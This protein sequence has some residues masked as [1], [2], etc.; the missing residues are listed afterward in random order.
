[1]PVVPSRFLVRVCVA[2]L[3]ASALAGVGRAQPGPGIRFAVP[4]PGTLSSA[5]NVVYGI[6]Q[7]PD[8]AIWVA[9][10][11]GLHRYDGVAFEAFRADPERPDAMPGNRVTGVSVAPDGDVWAAVDRFGLVR[12][13]AAGR[14]FERFRLPDPLAVDPTVVVDGDGAVWVGS[15]AWG[16]AMDVKLD[17]TTRDVYRLD[18]ARRTLHRAAGVRAAPWGLRRGP[19]GTLWVATPEGPVQRTASGWR[20]HRLGA[21]HIVPG[22]PVRVVRGRDLFEMAPSGRFR[23][24]AAPDALRERLGAAEPLL[25][26][27]GERLWLYPEEGGLVAVDLGSG[28]AVTYAHDPSRSESLPDGVVFRMLEDREGV[29]WLGTG[30]GLRTLTP[31]WDVFASVPVGAGR[32][33][34]VVAQGASGRVWGGAACAV[35]GELLP[36]ARLRPLAEAEPAVA[37]ALARSGLCVSN[38]LEAR[39]GTFWFSGW[40]FRGG[41]DVAGV[42]RVRPDGA[43]RRFRPTGAPGALPH[44]A[45]RGALEA[46]DGRIWVATEGGL[47][48]RRPDDTWETF[49]AAPGGLQ[50]DVVWSLA[51]AGDGRLWVGTYGGGLSRLDPATGRAA[52]WRHDAGDPA[53]LPSDAVTAI[54]PSAAQPGVV[55]VGTYDGGLARLVPSTGRVTRVGRAEGLPSLTVKSVVED[56]RGRLWIGT[57]AGLVRYDPATREVRVYT[58]ADGL[59]SSAFGMYDAAA[60]ADGT[61]AFGAGVDLVA[62]DPE[63]TAPFAFDAPVALRA[64]RIDGTRRALPAPGQPVRLRPGERAV[65]AEVVALSFRAPERL[66]YAVRLDG[67]DAQWLPLGA[68]RSAAW[69]G[70]APGTYRLRARAGVASGTWSRRELSVPVVVEPA[71]WQRRAVRGLAALLAVGLFGLAVRDLSQ[72][73]LR[74][75]V[76]ALEVAQRLQHERERISRDLHD[77]VGAQLSSLL[78]GVELARLARA[79]GAPPALGDPLDAVE[80]D[81]RTTMRQLRETIWALHGEAVSLDAFCDRVRADLAARASALQAEVSCRGDAVVLSPMQALNLYRIVQEAVTNTLKYAGA[82]RIAVRLVHDGETVTVEVADDGA[83]RP[84]AAPGDGAP[85]ASLGGFGMRSMAARA[86]ALGGTFALDAAAGTTV[87][88]RVPAEASLGLPASGEAPAGA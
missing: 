66:R 21:A 42:L 71:W 60:F 1:M 80:G 34:T 82:T 57:D 48:G 69:A 9:S 23:R 11:L 27:R 55:W 84:P 47:A 86:E 7:A 10:E 38:V 45:S 17:P 67:V 15:G 3:A 18:P 20:R 64:L 41:A 14:R 85:G 40:P 13:A 33:A 54:V 49:A 28:R 65:G 70:L 31:G 8:G 12:Y 79:R 51:D 59:P 25:V 6:E 24:R 5:T 30:G 26:D 83:F 37:T 19:D 72:R 29:L 58:E 78:A 68:D 32:L 52:T 77:H 36:D 88:V 62:F 22:D 44:A 63:R 50:A 46:A 87:R 74:R 81:A 16:A 53:T 43:A 39:D 76:Q 75:Q 73:R 2:A 56:A 4:S 61:L 35:P